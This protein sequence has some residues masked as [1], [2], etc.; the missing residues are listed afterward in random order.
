M[1]TWV[2]VLYLIL[3]E[4][5]SPAPAGQMVDEPTCRLAGTAMAT[6]LEERNPGTTW[7]YSCTPAVTA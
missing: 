3:P 6:W 1:T 5:A 7:R 4:G 2:L